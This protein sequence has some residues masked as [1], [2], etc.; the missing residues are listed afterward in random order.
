MTFPAICAY[1]FHLFWA[2]ETIW[3]YWFMNIAVITFGKSN[4]IL[5]IIFKYCY[6]YDVMK[7]ISIWHDTSNAYELRLKT[8]QFYAIRCRLLFETGTCIWWVKRAVILSQDRH[9]LHVRRRL[10]LNGSVTVPVPFHS[11]Q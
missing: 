3:S 6:Y 2:N 10:R 8:Y 4:H 1:R 11:D 7:I 9:F 5:Q